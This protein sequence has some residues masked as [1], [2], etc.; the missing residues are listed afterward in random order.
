MDPLFISIDA[1][2]LERRIAQAAR[3]DRADEVGRLGH[4][5]DSGA[6]MF[7][8]WAQRV[9]GS[10]IGSVGDAV[11]VTVPAD[12]IGELPALI[13][14]YEHAV[15][16]SLSV[17]VGTKLSEAETALAAAKLRG[18]DQA[19]LY[20][21][22]VGQEVAG[23]APD[24]D[25]KTRD[26]FGL[27]KGEPP[28]DGPAQGILPV[29]TTNPADPAPTGNAPNSPMSVAGYS[30]A[31]ADQA[32]IDDG[33]REAPN[34]AVKGAGPSLADDLRHLAQEQLDAT[35]GRSRAAVAV[36]DG[37]RTRLVSILRSLND[38]AKLRELAQS[39]P[40]VTDVLSDLVATIRDL[41]RSLPRG[42][43]RP[44][45]EDNDPPDAEGTPVE[46]AGTG[47]EKG[48]I[49]VVLPVG[50]TKDGKI[51]VGDGPPGM[52][53]RSH[54]VSVRAGMV[55]GPENSHAVSSRNPGGG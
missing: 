12:R 33:N 27:G 32:I 21:D 36:A 13:E 9:G 46:K 23:Q 55:L 50:A 37:T 3:A 51:K 35:A 2:K 48:R 14:Q 25:Q 28:D 43:G 6:A 17:G 22:A 44:A 54:W 11:R 38:P 10:A 5:I 52:G 49:H 26:E 47:N 42:A 24:Q 15:G 7:C 1:D 40:G 30:D 18:G 8:S 41:A 4:A 16:T 20:S 34:D 19:V 39:A 53:G 45:H 31:Q 29:S